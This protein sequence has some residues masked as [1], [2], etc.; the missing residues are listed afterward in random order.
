[1]RIKTLF[2]LIV[3][4]MTTAGASDLLYQITDG[5]FKTNNEIPVSMN[6]GEHY[7]LMTN[8]QTIIKFN[9]KQVL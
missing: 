1:M 2:M 3:S 8:K 5:A 7:T 4:A 9:Y 6:D